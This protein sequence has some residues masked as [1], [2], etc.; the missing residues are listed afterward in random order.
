[1]VNREMESLGLFVHGALAFGHALGLFYNVRRGNKTDATIHGLALCYDT[2][3]AYKHYI[4]AAPKKAYQIEAERITA[5]DVN[6]YANRVRT[7]YDKREVW[8]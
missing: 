1:M 3:A 2:W 6:D 8:W 4:D 7:G 5:K